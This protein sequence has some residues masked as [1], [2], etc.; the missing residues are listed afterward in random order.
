MKKFLPFLFTIISFTCFAQHTD[1]L[2]KK[3]D[4]DTSWKFVAEPALL[5]NQ[6]S[7]ANWSAG[8][9]NSLTLTTKIPIFLDYRTEKVK[10]NNI[11]TLAYGLS[12]QQEFK[13]LRKTD[14]KIAFTSKVGVK[15]SKQW[16]YG[17]LFQF[18]TQMSKGYVYPNDSVYVSKF[19]APAYFQFSLGFNYRP[20]EFFSV[21]MSPLGS[22]L[23]LVT[24]KELTKRPEGAF[25]IFDGN[26]TLWQVGASLNALLKKDIFKNVA[27]L[28]KLDLFSDYKNHPQNIVVSWENNM[29]FK[30]NSFINVSLFTHLIHDPNSPYIDSNGKA[31]GSRIQ[32]KENFGVGF[33][34]KIKK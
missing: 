2:I 4:R 15:A 5:F 18:S 12:K 28:S 27:L 8:G 24:D 25:G 11:F 3:A 13:K 19:M 26:T 29:L 9:S 20:Y 23:T 1:T 34:Y 22:R 21:F 17:A 14:D 7:F 33:T 32:F 6:T 31:H 16:D 10:W 30:V